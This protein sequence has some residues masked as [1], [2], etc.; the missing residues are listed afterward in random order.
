MLQVSRFV[1]S[2]LARHGKNATLPL[3]FKRITSKDRKAAS[4]NATMVNL[5]LSK[6]LNHDWAKLLSSDVLNAVFVNLCAGN[7]HDVLSLASRIAQD[8]LKYPFMCTDLYLLLLQLLSASHG[9]TRPSL[10]IQLCWEMVQVEPSIVKQKMAF[11]LVLETMRK[12]D[13]FTQLLPLRILFESLSTG[14]NDENIAMDYL[15]TVICVLLNSNQYVGAIEHFELSLK[16]FLN[17]PDLL[18]SLNSLQIKNLYSRLPINC[19]ITAMYETQDCSSL[20]LLLKGI[21]QP[22][23]EELISIEQWLLALSLGLSLNHYGLVRL[24]YNTVIAINLNET[25]SVD[26]VIFDNK[27]K[28]LENENPI[29]R[30]LTESTVSSILHTLASHGDIDLCLAFIELHYIHKGLKGQRGLSKELCIDIVRAYCFH[31]PITS[32]VEQGER[33]EL[34]MRVIDVFHNFVL[35]RNGRFSYK[36]FSDAFLQ[37]ILHFRVFDQNIEK[38]IL[39]ENSISQKIRE[40]AEEEDQETTI[41]PRKVLGPKLLGSQQGNVFMN[42]SILKSFV[43]EHALYIINKKY[44]VSTLQLFINCVLD[45]VHKYQNLS[46]FVTVFEALH[47]INPEY[48]SEWLDQDLLFLLGQCLGTSP[49]SM[50]CG[51]HI[52]QYLS[53]TNRQISSSVMENFIYS[54]LRNPSYTSL[55]EYLVFCHLK[56]SPQS[57][58][59][60]LMD[61]LDKWSKEHVNFRPVV[62]FLSHQR[63]N[64]D[65]ERLWTTSDFVTTALQ[66]LPEHVINAKYPEVDLRDLDRLRVVMPLE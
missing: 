48:A 57:S 30:S 56:S 28:R 19:L 58:S 27:L 22:Y 60:T 44:H 42:V 37:K 46:G 6:I 35:N 1:D 40:T 33:D 24:V 49:A 12:T 14:W 5:R 18:N 52:F 55:F 11:G 29:L 25:L 64:P 53:G 34:V 21:P 4:R 9:S 63:T 15:G 59:V 41:L 62:D 61:R 26:D 65:W 39:K 10:A 13:D 16:Q 32:L 23:E 20:L 17:L 50:A 38:Q 54:S 45:H 3:C 66:V 8:A 43:R 31:T 36:D 51:F 2:I 7:S 47:D